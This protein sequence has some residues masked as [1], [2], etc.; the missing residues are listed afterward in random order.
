M[1][2]TFSKEKALL[3][4]E[5]AKLRDEYNELLLK[6]QSL[7]FSLQDKEEDTSENLPLI[8]RIKNL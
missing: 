7:M 4:D 2:T 5:N 1:A 8:D 6:N 3:K